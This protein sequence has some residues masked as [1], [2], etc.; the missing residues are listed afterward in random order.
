VLGRRALHQPQGG[1]QSADGLMLV[2]RKESL[3][4]RK[5][6]LE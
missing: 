2:I 5:G 1:D 6:S 4:I 3:V